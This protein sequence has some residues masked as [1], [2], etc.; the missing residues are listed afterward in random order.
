MQQSIILDSRNVE[1][2]LDD[3][4]KLVYTLLPDYGLGGREEEGRSSIIAWFSVVYQA[5]QYVYHLNEIGSFRMIFHL[6]EKWKRT[7]YEE[8][9]FFKL[10]VLLRSDS[11]GPYP[12][13]LCNSPP[14]NRRDLNLKW[15]ISHLPSEIVIWRVIYADR[16]GMC[17]GRRISEAEKSCRDCIASKSDWMLLVLHWSLNDH[18]RMRTSTD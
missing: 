6:L 4:I 15:I 8:T 16:I 13:L 18:R 1:V 9:S 3:S 10:T 2:N 5:M 7:Q 17:S 11:Q 12:L 14:V